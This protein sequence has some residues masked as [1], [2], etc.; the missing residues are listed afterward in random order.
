L[1]Q[2]QVQVFRFRLPP[3]DPTINEC[4]SDHELVIAEIEASKNRSAA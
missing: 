2:L 3:R 1:Q 4:N